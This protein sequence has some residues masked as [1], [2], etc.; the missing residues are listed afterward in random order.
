MV[1]YSCRS[2]GADSV[3][4]D[5]S[6]NTVIIF[7]SSILLV[8]PYYNVAFIYGQALATSSPGLLNSPHPPPERTRLDAATPRPPSGQPPPHPPPE[9]KSLV[10]DT[11][12]PARGQPP[13]L[14]QLLASIT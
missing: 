2:F 8:A 10:G 14:P 11:P 13:P 6:L 3:M 4:C 12:R 1:R 5:A 7:L 9:R